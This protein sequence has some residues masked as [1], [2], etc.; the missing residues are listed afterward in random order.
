MGLIC[1]VQAAKALFWEPLKTLWFLKA[2]G[3]L[4]VDEGD[5]DVPGALGRLQ[6]LVV[7][8]QPPRVHQHPA[9][10]R[11][12]H[13]AVI[14]LNVKVCFNLTPA[15]ALLSLGIKLMIIWIYVV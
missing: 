6:P 14:P 13:G 8:R 10:P 5:H 15:M 11:P 4:R 12:R 1:G 7:V 3:V 2:L 9:L